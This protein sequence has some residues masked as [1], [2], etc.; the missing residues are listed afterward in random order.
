MIKKALFL[1]LLVFL[2]L[3][4]DVA[5]AHADLLK[6][7]PAPDE[8]LQQQPSQVDLYF[9]EE[10]EP[11]QSVIAVFDARGTQVD[12]NDTHAVDRDKKHLAVSL[13]TFKQGYYIVSWQVISSDD[14]H[15]TVGSYSFALGVVVGDAPVS[16]K[17]NQAPV[18]PAQMAVKGILYLATALLAGGMVFLLF[19]WQA[20][21]RPVHGIPDKEK[22]MGWGKL[23]PWRWMM[24]SGLILSAVAT[25][26][27]VIVQA[28][29]SSSGPAA[30]SIMV[31]KMAKLVSA[32]RDSRYGVQALERL[33][34]LA[35]LAWALTPPPDRWNRWV[36]LPLSIFILLT[37]S[38]ESHAAALANPLLPVGMDLLHLAAASIWVG[39]LVF[40]LVSL[41]WSR[42]LD[43]E[44]R[45]RLM[46]GILVRFSSIAF[47]SVGILGITGVY[48]ALLDIDSINQFTGTPY[49]QALIAK[50]ALAGVLVMLGGY[51]RFVMSPRI[52]Q[53]TPTDI[54]LFKRF[55]R[56]LLLE[57]T[58]GIIL[59]MWVGVF[60]SLPPTR[61]VI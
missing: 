48:E 46:A 42:R 58:L 44:T 6:A 50:V 49:G 33:V 53:A 10:V 14:A 36:A 21:A 40:L 17:T 9:S 3:P 5:S 20:A 11:S 29:I 61:L 59:L 51:N 31:L 57:T 15:A 4:I 54:A 45:I 19:V 23:I 25:L 12:L 22:Q 37:I 47:A 35:L 16:A 28:A 26:L 7:S 30:F 18:F 34:A 32:F 2:L 55:H 43:G 13:S 8:H 52:E 56:F 41:L 24:T 27:G 60:T 38:L 1:L 39:G